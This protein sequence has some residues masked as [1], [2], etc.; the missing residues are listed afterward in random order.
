V[1][2]DFGLA[3]LGPEEPLTHPGTALGT[4]GYMSP[5]QALGRPSDPRSDLFSF[6]RVLYE[7]ATGAPPS[8]ALKLNALAPELKRIIAKCL[9]SDCELRYQQASEIRADLE[10][11][12][13][14][15]GSKKNTVKRWRVIAALAAALIAI[16][17]A[18][19]FY[20]HR[21]PKLTD[22]D[23]IVLADFVNQ[24]GDPVF[25]GTLRQGLAVELE[26]SPFLS[27]VSDGS[28]Q[29][30]LRLMGQPADARLTP[31][32]AREICER[33]GSA[34]VLEGSIAPLGSRYVLGLRARN[35]LTGDVLDD[36]QA[37]AAG[38]EDVLN[39]LSQIA[40][41]F[42][43]RAG[44]SLAIVEKHSV[45]LAETTTPS[46]E[47][48]KA[49][50]MGWK[51]LSSTGGP[52]AALPFF[53]RA[54]EI[55]PQFATAHAW[56]GRMYADIGEQVL[57]VESTSKAWELRE[58]ASDQEK[59]FIDFSYQRLVMG[60]LEKAHQICE[61]W[62]RAY[63]RDM[64]PHA[65]LASSTSTSLGRFDSATEE[66]KKAIELD[67]DHPF[68]YSNLAASY[69]FR[70][71]LAEAQSSLQRAA[72]RKLDAPELLM[73][74][75]QIAFLQD[76]QPEMERLAALGEERSGVDDGMCDMEASVLAYSGRL[77]QARVKSLHAVDLALQAD[78]R[79]RAA[80]HE[81][82]SAVREALFGHAPESRRAAL[83]AHDL[84]NGRD[85]QYGAA[86]ALGLT[87]DS[88]LAQTLAND[89][90][91]RFPEDTFVKF[92][93]LPA[94]RALFALNRNEPLKAIEFLQAAAPY[95]LGWQA[96]GSAGFVGS[97]YPI[98][99]RGDAYLA[100]HQ[101]A[102]AAVEFQKILDHRGIVGADPIGALARLQLARA[103]VQAGN[104]TNAKSAYQNFLALWKDADPDIP[105]F[106]E[107]KAEN[108]ALQIRAE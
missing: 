39:A 21:V 6:G 97:L 68:A 35:C 83:A 78:H 59:F 107:A 37:Q 94:L 2:L 3:Q 56:L 27:L 4:A 51:V 18:A 30:A 67:P 103:F 8:A 74:R 48:L 77:Q 9:E 105:I 76:D 20:L 1:L 50:S 66:G 52:P 73:L 24:T 62:A 42:R 104:V 53:K 14:V 19:Y 84:S 23:T 10:R 100:A 98:Y 88:S 29:K 33:T 60:N 38:K 86:L 44:E 99:V 89:L 75:Y 12:K 5:E 22:K 32:L 80:E 95:E 72:E 41:R 45:P 96:S 7:M 65:F 34:A 102:R 15:A 55:D 79:E 46:L 58:R 16:F 54:T 69:M 92:S 26:Q 101:G 91:K 106:K 49:Y 93:Y 87:L 13:L 64:R 63:P 57:S 31:E 85:V 90:E 82:G 47:A 81:A 25:D 36:E 28:V 61:L 71:R 17:A 70:N 11:L 43:A 40:S 108:A